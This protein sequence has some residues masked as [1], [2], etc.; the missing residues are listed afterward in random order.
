M[1]KNFVFMISRIFIS[2][3]ILGI[4]IYYVG[5]KQIL[6]TFVSMKKVFLIPILIL[7]I[8]SLLIGA[9]NIKILIKKIKNKLSFRKIL[10]YYL[11]SWSIGSI[12]PG[13]IG[14]F[15]I[16]YMLKK[17]NISYGQSLAITM[18]DKII[19]I[20]VLSIT[21]AIT[22]I[23]LT[24]VKN[25]YKPIIFVVMIIIF[26][27]AL[28]AKI[29]RDI[30]KRIMPKKFAD[31]FKK[32]N[33]TL[34]FFIKNHKK[35]LTINFV[36]TIIKW[37]IT[38]LGITL[39]FFSFGFK[40]NPIIITA[41][42]MSLTI[43]S[44]IPITINGIGLRETAAVYLYSLL[45]AKPEVVISAYLVMTVINYVFAIIILSKRKLIS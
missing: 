45:G 44:L 13:K 12:M 35:E 7:H 31:K 39:L 8:I 34:N 16:L 24:E 2:I 5:I 9:L 38:G 4:L 28:K 11:V 20:I 26:L 10:K 1:K 33:K 18:I 29:V 6:E 27:I 25:F 23:F 41:I 21:A 37:I 42:S 14:E 22:I 40:T 3:A 43:I 15:S 17:E 30:I 36:L 32:F 19:T